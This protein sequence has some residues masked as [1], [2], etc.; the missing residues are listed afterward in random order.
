M[1]AAINEWRERWPNK[2]V[3]ENA[4]DDDVLQ[5]PLE[6]AEEDRE[7]WHMAR[8]FDGIADSLGGTSAC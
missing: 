7:S 2:L 5:P 8:G 6:M 1:K 3:D 4:G